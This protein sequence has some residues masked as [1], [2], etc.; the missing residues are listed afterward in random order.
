MTGNSINGTERF[1]DRLARSLRTLYRQF[2]Y[3]HYRMSKFEEYELYVQNKDFIGSSGIISFT[4]T[5]G[6]L[7]ALKPDVT[8]SIIKSLRR[9]KETQKV[10]YNENVYRTSNGTGTFRESPQCGLECIGE[11]G[12]Y[13]ICEVLYLALLSLKEIGKPFRLVLSHMELLLSWIRSS[14]IPETQQETLFRCIKQKNTDGIRELA[15]QCGCDSEK[16]ISAIRLGGD[17]QEILP[18]LAAFCGNRE[19]VYLKELE[20]VTRVMIDMGFPGVLEIDLSIVNDMDYY[21]GIVF[22]GYV[23][24]IPEGVL[25]GGCYDRM[26]KKTGRDCSAIGFAVYLDRLERIETDRPLEKDDVL[27]LYSDNTAPETVLKAVSNLAE[28][29]LTV[30]ASAVRPKNLRYGSIFRLADDGTLYQIREEDRC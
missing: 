10:F 4:D 29:G 26:M 14:G 21:S 11:I 28:K 5:D 2:G 20:K 15:A 7:L 24:G 13:D 8:L 16:L 3:S 27:L 23:E 1:E 19:I 25:S 17:P 18:K 22:R 12:P 9:S 30:R 6:R